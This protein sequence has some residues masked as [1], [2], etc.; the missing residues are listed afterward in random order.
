MD[1]KMKR[2]FECLIPVTSCNLK[3]GYCYVIQ[4]D[5]RKMDL[6]TL[7]YSPETI[8]A[9]LTQERLGGVC[10]FSICGA[11]E[12]LLPKETV[13]IVE[14]L[15]GNGHYVNITTNGTLK[16]RFD[17]ILM[18]PKENLSRLHFAFSLHYNELLRLGLLETFFD[19]IRKVRQAGCSF[20]LQINLCDEYLEQWDAIKEICIREVGAV[21][22]V[23]ATRKEKNDGCSI[24]KVELLTD[25][26]EEEYI[27]IGNSYK[28]PLFD[29]TMKNF[30]ER[31]DE[32]CYAGAWSGTLNLETGILS[33]CYGPDQQDIFADLSKPIDF[34][35]VGQCGSLFCMNSSHFLSLG[36]IP[37]MLT[38][39]YAN[40]RN[41]KEAEWYTERMA[42]FLNQKLADNNELCSEKEKIRIRRK[43]RRK[44]MSIKM[45]NNIKK[46]IKKVWKNE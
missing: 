11:G 28:S 34:T 17:E 14:K 42:S 24:Q 6:P 33:K 15:L 9:G 44:W 18:L 29:F 38:P 37:E 7:K 10:Y 20:V 25:M 26:T 36:V 41:R 27:K 8:G 13:Q 21:P 40:L 22:Q 31:R 12:T 45:K 23:A 35:P 3:C 39:T 16:K 32:F 46:K 4:R 5:N 1:D 30:N 43:T 2:F 19:N